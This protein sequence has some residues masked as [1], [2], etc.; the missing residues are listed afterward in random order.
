MA[1]G[2]RAAWTVTLLLLAACLLPDLAGFVPADAGDASDAGDG[3]ARDVSTVDVTPIEAGVPDGAILYFPFEEGVAT[4]TADKSG[5]GNDGILVGGGAMAWTTS[6]KIGNALAFNVAPVDGGAFVDIPASKSSTLA[7]TGS[8]SVTAWIFATSAPVDDA[9]IVSNLLFSPTTP[10][11]FQLDT[12]I[13][14]G[15]RALGFKLSNPADAGGG[16][17]ARYGATVFKLDTWYFVAGVYDATALTLH[18]YVDGKLD[19]GALAGSVLSE[20]PKSPLDVH[21]GHRPSSKLSNFSGTIDE[22][23]VYPRALS[24]VEIAGL[25]LQ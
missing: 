18:V 5:N 3:A 20:F 6:G 12:T 23:R 25:F 21:I 14:K 13:D 17:F 15:P 22:V 7:V 4:S 11:G 24:D 10:G 16:V 2:W 9:T 19:D 8:F 1:T